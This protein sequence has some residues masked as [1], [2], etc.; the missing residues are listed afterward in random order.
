V[1]GLPGPGSDVDL[2]LVLS[3]ADK[4]IRERV[5]E[6]LPIGFPV[7]IDLFVYT[8]EEFEQLREEHPGW[9]KTICSGQEV[10]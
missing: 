1:S 4:P 10:L 3:S 5:A 6:F 7:G 2:C 8:R 9:Y